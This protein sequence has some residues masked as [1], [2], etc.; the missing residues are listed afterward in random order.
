LTKLGHDLGDVYTFNNVPGFATVC[1]RLQLGYLY[2]KD[3]FTEATAGGF[4]GLPSDPTF[5]GAAKLQI[6]LQ[7][8][9]DNHCTVPDTRPMW[10]TTTAPPPPTGNATP[11]HTYGHSG[12]YNARVT[13]D[14][15]VATATATVAIVVGDD[16]PPPPPPPPGGG[17][18]SQPLEGFG[19]QT[20]GG[21]GGNVVHVSDA[22]DAAVRHAFEV[23]N[24]ASGPTIIDFD[25]PGPITIDSPILVTA[26]NL[27][28]EGNAATLVASSGLGETVAATLQFAGHDVI[29]RNIRLRNGGD[30]LRAQ[31]THDNPDGTYNIVFDHI[32]STGANDDGIS[33]GYGSHDVTVQY[34]FLAGNDRS[35]FIKY[36]DTTRV[37]LH[38]NWIMKQWIRGPMA[39]SS[40]FV[41]IRN[42]IDQDWQLWGMR[43]EQHASGNVINTLYDESSYAQSHF[44][45]SQDGMINISDQPVYT[46]GLV[47]VNA[48]HPSYDATSDT[49]LPAAP[50]TTQSVADMVP[51]VH[52]NAGAMPRDSID[53]QYIDY[54][55][56]WSLGDRNPLRLG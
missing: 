11:S 12:H 46:S 3:Q 33:I 31:P 56:A 48:A 21:A 49:E 38:H 32:S 36:G 47:F 30:N 16:P 26:N 51:N 15:G 13:V 6:S 27:T 28:V 52:A 55:G 9:H 4:P 17:N 54:T 7:K 35:I 44:G 40:A 53:Q 24:H 10:D 37:S 34:S 39:S 2:F 29:V 5:G 14:D 18:V 20:R 23:A 43:Y 22:T 45:N 42:D 1:D 25:V 41:D 50:V 19:A 8:L